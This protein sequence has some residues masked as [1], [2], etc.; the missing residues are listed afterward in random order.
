MSEDYR[1][2]AE[3]EC[4]CGAWGSH[5]CDCGGIRWR[6]H[7]NLP[8]GGHYYSDWM[9]MNEYYWENDDGT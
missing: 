8:D 9:D 3:V 1:P 2:V 6:W 7:Q 4:A 5:M